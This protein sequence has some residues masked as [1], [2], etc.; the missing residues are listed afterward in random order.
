VAEKK[1]LGH[2]SSGGSRF[3]GFNRWVNREHGAINTVDHHWDRL[4]DP[5]QLRPGDHRDPD[6]VGAALATTPEGWYSP[7]LM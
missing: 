4:G 6:R 7:S 3:D 5:R 1:R 2:F